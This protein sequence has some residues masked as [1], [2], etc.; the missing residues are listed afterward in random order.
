MRKM[1]VKYAACAAVALAAAW[2]LCADEADDVPDVLFLMNGDSLHGRLASAT[3]AEGVVWM[4]PAVEQKINFKLP[5][6]KEIRLQ[7][8]SLP[9]AG[10]TSPAFAVALLTNGDSL[11]GR[12]VSLDGATVVFETDYAGSLGIKRKMIKAILPSLGGRFYAYRGPN[13]LD[14]WEEFPR[15]QSGWSF[16]NGMLYAA[17]DRNG[18]IAKNVSLPERSRI[19]F[20]LAWKSAPQFTLKF[21]TSDFKN[22]L[23]EGHALSVNGSMISLRRYSKGAGMGFFGNL[24]LPM[25]AAANEADFSII[26]SIKDSAVVLLVDGILVKEFRDSGGMLASGTGISFASEGKLRISD[27]AVSSWEADTPA[28]PPPPGKGGDT[29]TLILA[30]KDILAGVLEKIQDNQ[31]TFSMNAS[32]LTLPVDRVGA[33]EFASVKLQTP[34]KFPEDVKV[35]L[36]NQ[37]ILTG[38]FDGVIDGK[39]VCV[40]E[41]F[42]EARINLADVKSMTFNIYTNEF[43]PER[44]ADEAW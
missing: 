35:A 40:S 30:N 26:T 31:L 38:R 34:R 17:G 39:L 9:V 15:K 14:E 6:V 22:P 43:F 8:K 13:S 2:A 19:D 18:T 36:K 11:V 16:R 28:T 29:D 20:H 1:C 12:L 7:R 24:S 3:P 41:A 4:T 33:I 23:A 10:G 27:I 25:L 21:Y 44:K 42:G 5:S 37:G 32:P